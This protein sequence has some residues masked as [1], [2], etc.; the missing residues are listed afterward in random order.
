MANKNMLVIATS[1]DLPTTRIRSNQYE[2]TIDEPES[3]G[4][5]ASAPSPVEALLGA[6]ASC[7]IAAGHWVANEMEME[8]KD[9][10]V[11]VDGVI[12]SGKFLGQSTNQRAGFQS[13]SIH[14][15]INSDAPE[16]IKSE[17]L[18][19]VMQRCPVI[20]N[21]L[22]PVDIELKLV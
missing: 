14:V 18:A 22:R 13:I 17:W 19:E 7:V 8:I 21:L 20:D 16:V 9:M 4:G 12:D 11:T 15:S 5:K 6:V 1:S 2:W 10:E 3:F